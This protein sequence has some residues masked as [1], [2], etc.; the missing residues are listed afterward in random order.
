MKQNKGMIGLSRVSPSTRD[1]AAIFLSFVGLE[2]NILC[3]LALLLF[4]NRFSIWQTVL[5]LA[6][7]E[8]L[9]ITLSLGK[10]AKR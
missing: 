9:E 3:Q 10:Y 4:L 8:S 1:G 6:E 5:M 2:Q 7:L